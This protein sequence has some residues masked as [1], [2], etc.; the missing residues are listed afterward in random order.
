M[1]IQW[2]QLLVGLSMGLLPPQ[3]F[4]TSGC[5]YLTFEDLWTKVIRPE[6][7][8]QRRRRWWKLP[9]AWIDPFRGYVVARYLIDSFKASPDATAFHRL[10]PTLISAFL[11]GL[12]L[13]LQTRGREQE[14]ETL[15]PA[16]FLGGVLFAMLPP[17]VAVA[18]MVMGAATALALQ[19]YAAG[20]FVAM[21]T[22]AGVGYVFMGRSPTLAIATIMAGLPMIINWFRG[23]RLVMPVRC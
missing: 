9:L 6:Q 3:L 4:I 18:G 16:A 15:S 19:G 8:G 20:Y 17:T 21:V 12:C 14:R 1:I 13:W 10:L 22:T 23:T 2:L 11:I 7:Q 5:R